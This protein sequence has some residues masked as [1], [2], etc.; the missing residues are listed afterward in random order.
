VEPSRIVLA[1]HYRMLQGLLNSHT[2]ET[3]TAEEAAQIGEVCEFLKLDLAYVAGLP[4][5]P[6]KGSED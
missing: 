6:D 4:R 2:P 1:E 5:Y 3:L